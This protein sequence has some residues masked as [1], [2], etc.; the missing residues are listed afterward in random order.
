MQQDNVIIY[1][2]LKKKLFLIHQV[3]D[4]TYTGCPKKGTLTVHYGIEEVTINVRK[5]LK[6][7][8]WTY[9]L[10]WGSLKVARNRSII[11]KYMY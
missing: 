1:G 10:T 9:L 11:S 3:G 8:Y 5:M 7:F 2:R 6:K 4:C